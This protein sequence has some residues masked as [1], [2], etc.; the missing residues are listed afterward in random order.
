M[1]TKNAVATICET[2]FSKMRKELNWHRSGKDP[3]GAF[4]GVHLAYIE[5]EQLLKKYGWVNSK[6]R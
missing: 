3:I 6:L 5:A 1:P 4:V 2:L